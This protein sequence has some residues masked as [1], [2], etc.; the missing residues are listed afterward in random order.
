MK[1]SPDGKTVASGWGDGTI[2]L[3]DVA[4]RKSVATFVTPKAG[5]NPEETILIR[6]VAFSPDGKTLASGNSGSTTF[7]M[8]RLWDV[9]SGK[10]TASFNGYRA[11]FVGLSG[12]YCVVFSPDGKT[13]ATGHEDRVIRPC[14]RRQRQDH[15]QIRGRCRRSNSF[16]GVQPGRE[17]P[18]FG[19]TCRKIIKLW[20]VTSGKN[21]A[22]FKAD[23]LQ[24][25][26]A[27]SPDG[28]TLAGGVLDERRQVMGCRYRQ[29]IAA[30]EPDS[31]DRAA[32]KD[33]NNMTNSV[34]FSPDGKTLALGCYNGLIRVLDVTT[35]KKIAA[36]I[37]HTALVRSLASTP[38]ARLWPRRVTTALV[39]LW[40][41][42]NEA[43]HRQRCRPHH[44]IGRRPRR[45]EKGVIMP[46]SG[47]SPPH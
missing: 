35:G 5:G 16:R 13:L 47:Q 31:A 21:T 6:S 29:N 41:A 8:I 14:G 7:G 27:F 32:I 43:R 20:D 44:R 2:K 28:R 38:M 15:R 22:T 26:V 23:G 37:G 30:F 25:S 40:A 1:F 33:P 46:S 34:A 11:P 24:P 3:W 36:L 18:G 19:R 17:N 9:A 45:R 12:I 10:N 39:K 42:E 4:T